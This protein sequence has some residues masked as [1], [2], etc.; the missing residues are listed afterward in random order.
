MKECRNLKKSQENVEEKIT[1]KKLQDK[2]S[3]KIKY[4]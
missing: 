2:K 1:N 3:Q 4:Q